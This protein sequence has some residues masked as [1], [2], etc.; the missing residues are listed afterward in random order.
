ML[1]ATPAEACSGDSACLPGRIVT[2]VPANA[3][4]LGGLLGTYQQDQPDAG[5]VVFSADGG[6]VAYQS[7]ATVRQTV[8][9]SIELRPN[10]A[11]APGERYVLRSWCAL[12]P[13]DQLF[14]V[15]PPQPLPT[16]SG[17][18]SVAAAGREV[19][20]LGG[21]RDGRCTVPTDVA[22]ARFKIAPS[23]DVVPFLGVVAWTLDVDGA[24]WARETFGGMDADG[25]LGKDWA[26]LWRQRRVDDEAFPSD[27]GVALGPHT[28]TLKA[29][30]AGGGTLTAAETKFSLDCGVGCSAAGGAPLVLLPVL[31]LAAAGAANW[32]GKRS[33]CAPRPRRP[34][35]RLFG[36]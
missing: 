31:L 34:P 35:G 6:L 27:R 14:T 13:N 33:G 15:T 30:L 9:G 25:G 19:R 36:W 3:P 5:P 1:Q 4:G 26:Q 20:E 29:H 11:L 32:R 2:D 8:N 24:E 7:L 12:G 10:V 22:F 18:I 21:A 23:A 17:S 28:A 16:T